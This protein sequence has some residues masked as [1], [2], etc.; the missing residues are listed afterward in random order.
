MSTPGSG[1]N[2]SKRKRDAGEQS[3][4]PELVI[5]VSLGLPTEKFFLLQKNLH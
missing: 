2:N 4:Q 1:N 3:V 5:K